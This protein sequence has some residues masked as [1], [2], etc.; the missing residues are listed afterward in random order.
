MIIL[1]C[2]DRYALSSP[3]VNIRAYSTAKF[4]L[5]M[6]GGGI[7]F[8]STV[9]IQLPIFITIQNNRCLSS[10]TYGLFFSIY[11][12]CLFGFIFPGLMIIFGILL[13]KHLK[14]I[15]IRVRPIQ[16]INNPQQQQLH[17]RDIN[18]MKFI[19]A[20]VVACFLLSVLAPINLMYAVLASNI[21]DKSQERIQIEGFASFM[22]LSLVFYLNYCMTF[23]L[24]VIMS[25]SFRREIKRVLL[26]YVKR[27]VHPHT[28]TAPGQIP[29]RNQ[30][31]R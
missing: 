15:R 30:Q 28:N 14:T 4:A 3:R 16:Q 13:W 19:L 24:Y 12:I 1:A 9:S 25:K 10:G 18:L 23:Y 5:K 20:E 7:V 11:Q 29:L 22:S 8:W 17:K 2:M 21:P 6:I 31:N 26:K 27:S